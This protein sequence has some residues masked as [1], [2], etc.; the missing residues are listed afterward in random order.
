MATTKKNDVKAGSKIG[1]STAATKTPPPAPKKK[2][3]PEPT[4]LNQPEPAVQTAPPP[5]P[6]QPATV[7][8]AN[9]PMSLLEAV[10]EMDATRQKMDVLTQQLANYKLYIQRLS[11][12]VGEAQRDIFHGIS[13]EGA[14]SSATPTDGRKTLNPNKNLKIS[15][16]RTY[17]WAKD[18]GRSAEEARQRVI[19]VVESTVRGKYAFNF[20][21]GKIPADVHEYI[22]YMYENYDLIGRKDANGKPIPL[23]SV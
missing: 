5:S 13:A 23:P 8:P 4:V 19:E 9:E 18:V 16:V 14:F 10:R 22:Q 20:P 11:E 2:E 12:I 3:K 7:E 15:A 1:R 21:D 17:G 6:P